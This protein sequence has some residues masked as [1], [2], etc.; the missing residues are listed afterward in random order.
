LEYKGG[1]PVFGNCDGSLNMM[2]QK[3]VVLL[4]ISGLIEW[5]FPYVILKS[6]ET[7]IGYMIRK[8]ELVEQNTIKIN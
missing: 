6:N 4:I 7:D 1:G 2:D 3:Q 5:G 8:L